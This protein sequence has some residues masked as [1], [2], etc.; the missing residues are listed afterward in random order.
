[1]SEHRSPTD[2]H[3]PLAIPESGVRAVRP[4]FR[5]EVST[6]E[7]AV[8][9]GVS[10]QSIRRAIGRGILPAVK[11][12]RAYAIHDEELARFARRR[13]LPGTSETPA[14]VVALSPFAAVPT[15]PVPGSRF[16]GREAE[17]AALDALLADPA[18][19]LITVTGPGAS[20]R[21]GWPC[22]RARRDNGTSWMARFLSTCR[23]PRCRGSSSPPSPRVWDS[24]NARNR[25][26]ATNSAPF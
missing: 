19:R 17:L 24:A 1:M 12:G 9:L 13:D 4:E 25:T 6:R 11:R 2:P 3:Q 15:L 5:R 20:A 14:L 10:E 16:V 22:R 21:H 26:G 23:R 18:E 7:A 8:A